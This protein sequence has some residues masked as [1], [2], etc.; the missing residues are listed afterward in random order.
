MVCLW[1]EGKGDG[2]GLKI[3]DFGEGN[4]PEE[5][6]GFIAGTPGYQAPEVANDGECS[7]ASDI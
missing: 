1:Q 3:I 6:A 4:T 7:Y 2:A 5:A